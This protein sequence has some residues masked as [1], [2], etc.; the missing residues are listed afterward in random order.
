MTTTEE[1]AFTTLQLCLLA[2]LGE[3]FS[4]TVEAFVVA[5]PL[6]LIYEIKELFSAPC[7]FKVFLEVH[8][9]RVVAFFQN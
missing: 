7:L 1:L 4:A 5:V 9:C 8:H 6:F 3:V 2:F